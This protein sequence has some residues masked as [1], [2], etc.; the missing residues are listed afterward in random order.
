MTALIEIENLRV[1]IPGPS[2]TLRAIRGVSLAIE[3]GEAFSIVGESGCGKSLTAMSILGLLPRKAIVSAERMRFDGK[4]LMQLSERERADIRGAE[5]AAIFQE[6]M[7]ALNPLLSIGEQMAEVFM[8]HGRGGRKDALKRAGEL[9]ERVGVLPVDR[10]L[11]QYPHE[12][13]GGLRQ[14]VMIA[15]ALMCRPK[16]LLADEPTTALDVTTQVEI[17]S[18][19]KELREDLGMALLLITHDL[20]VVAHVADRVAV[21]YAG[22]VVET[23]GTH[24][25]LMNASHPYTAALLRCL[26]EQATGGRPLVPIPGVVPALF[27]E[28]E[29]CMFRNR[30]ALERRECADPIPLQT[31]GS[32]HAY[33][34]RIPPSRIGSEVA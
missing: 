13:S 14:R 9:L 24:D 33:R 12:M 18:L 31:R 1:D 10:R 5:I 28:L 25:V 11:K 8:R 22:E 2:G 20:G 34:C 3:P 23:G 27:G 26:P 7:T 32:D 17:L 4:D 16:L 29:G 30:C 19:L 21:M 15:M 6:P